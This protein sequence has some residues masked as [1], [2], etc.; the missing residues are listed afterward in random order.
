[1]LQ[2]ILAHP[3]ATFM[4]LLGTLC[5]VGWP[6][7]RTRRRMLIVQIGIGVGFGLHYAL[8]GSLTASAVNGL[9][10]VQVALALAL[11]TRPGVQWI[12]WAFIPAVVGA[13]FLTWQGLPTIIAAA[14]TLVIAIGRVQSS[15]LRMRVLVLAGLPFWVL[16]DLLVS[17]PAVVADVLSL[18]V[19]VTLLLRQSPPP[20]D[21]GRHTRSLKVMRTLKAS[22]KSQVDRTFRSRIRAHG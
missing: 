22:A 8:L 11:G 4:A 13:A 14:G 10:A 15:P 2:S 20:A 7:A 5:M 21:M 3:L 19:G 1:M 9:G 17:S 12:G 16:H 6:L 18:I